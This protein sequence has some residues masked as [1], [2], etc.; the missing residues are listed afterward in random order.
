M[1]NKLDLLMNNVLPQT[2]LPPVLII[3][4]STKYSLRIEESNNV[5][6]KALPSFIGSISQ[7]KKAANAAGYFPNKWIRQ[8]ESRLN[9]LY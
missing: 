3:M 5:A 1:C 6:I 2:K 4:D 7:A 8:G 9:T